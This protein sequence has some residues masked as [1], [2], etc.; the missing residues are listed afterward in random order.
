MLNRPRPFKVSV[1]DGQLKGAAK[2]IPV[3]IHS[4]DQ[5]PQGSVDPRT[6]RTDD[7]GQ[8]EP[9]GD[10]R[11]YSKEREKDPSANRVERIVREP[12]R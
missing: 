11:R 6:W 4:N 1:V 7:N 5:R 3:G 8:P 12:I 10:Q 9:S 2:Q